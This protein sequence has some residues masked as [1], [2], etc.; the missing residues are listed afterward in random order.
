[1][2]QS[3]DLF[4]KYPIIKQYWDNTNDNEDRTLSETS[5]KKEKWICPYCKDKFIL[6]IADFIKRKNKCKNCQRKSNSVLYN[7]KIYR[8]WDKKKNTLNPRITS[9]HS[10]E[11]AFWKCPRCGEEWQSKIYNVKQG[12][13][14]CCDNRKR[15]RMGINDIFTL[16]P[17]LKL[18]YDFENNANINIENLRVSS[19]DVIRWKCHKCG[20]SWDTK[21]A[22]RIKKDSNGKYRVLPCPFESKTHPKRANEKYNFAILYPNLLKEWSS[23]NEL[24]P[25]KLLPSSNKIVK[26]DCLSNPSHHWKDSIKNRTIRGFRCK[27]CHPYKQAFSNRYPELEKYY[28]TKNIIPFNI[29]TKYSNEQVIWNCEKGHE[30]KKAFSQITTKDGRL[31]CPYCNNRKAKKGVNSLEDIYPEL[32][33]EWD[34]KTNSLLGL[35]PNKV[36][37]NTHTHSWWICSECKNSYSM[38]I[39]LKVKA[40]KRNKKTCKYCKN[41]IESRTHF[42]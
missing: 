37:P 4:V 10:K 24:D 18:D 1:M 35:F 34:Y 38:R 9:I 16:I 17:E 42:I 12:E 3:N 33:T 29:A 5:K 39:D 19:N 13:C 15:V 22:S 6:S 14:P 26:W 2:K 8:I 41:R 36:L 31:I 40:F 28:S 23:D 25:Y 11:L 7:K 27:I 32:L 30:F 21:L 20:Q